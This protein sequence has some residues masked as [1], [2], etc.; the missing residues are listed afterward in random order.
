MQAS[1]LGHLPKI[2]YWAPLN[3]SIIDSIL[4]IK[5]NQH[6]KN[7]KSLILLYSIHKD[8]WNKRNKTLQLILT[9]TLSIENVKVAKY[10]TCTPFRFI[11]P[12]PFDCNFLPF[13]PLLGKN[14][15][16][17]K[18]IKD[19]RLKGSISNLCV[20]SRHW[21]AWIGSCMEIVPRNGRRWN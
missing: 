8:D 16:S 20:L 19:L 2:D 3:Y 11:G 14:P 12:S 1:N 9:S 15:K 6:K 18:L 5:W 13:Q 21:Q 17:A 4:T 10:I 7:P